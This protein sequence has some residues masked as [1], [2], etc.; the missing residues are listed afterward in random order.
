M[1]DNISRRAAAASQRLG[2]TQD[3][4][5]M[6]DGRLGLVTGIAAVTQK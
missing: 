2:F 5:L 1:P 3:A 4:R 6:G